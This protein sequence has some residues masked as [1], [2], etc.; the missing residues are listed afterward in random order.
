M[1]ILIRVSQ[2]EREERKVPRPNLD[3]KHSSW[4]YLTNKRGKVAVLEIFRDHLGCKSFR[5]LYTEIHSIFG[6]GGAKKDKVT[7]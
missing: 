3:K 1:K 2:Y 5:I 4:T 7:S 6:P